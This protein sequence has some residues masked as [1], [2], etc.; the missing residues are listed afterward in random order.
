MDFL[1]RLTIALV[2]GALT[3]VLHA[4]GL[5]MAIVAI[6][7][8]AAALALTFKVSMRR[9]V[10]SWTITGGYMAAGYFIRTETEQARSGE[11]AVVLGLLQIGIAVLL[12]SLGALIASRL[13]QRQATAPLT[14]E[15]LLAE[16]LPDAPAPEWSMDHDATIGDTSIR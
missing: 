12:P 4:L 3:R 9:S 14:E 16:A 1:L 10:I 11:S 13:E 15:Q 6:I 2:A 8:G 5:P 7:I